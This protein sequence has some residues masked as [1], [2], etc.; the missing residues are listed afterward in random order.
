GGGGGGGGGGGE[1]G[2][3]VIR[4]LPLMLSIPDVARREL[5]NGRRIVPGGS[6][7]RTRNFATDLSETSGDYRAASFGEREDPSS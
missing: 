3:A 7:R 4:H 1:G 5:S 2:P 6:R